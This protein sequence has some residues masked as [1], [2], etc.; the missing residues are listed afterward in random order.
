MFKIY[1]NISMKHMKNFSIYILTLSFI[2]ASCGGGGGSSDPEP[3]TPPI[4]ASPVTM[5]FEANKKSIDY[6]DNLILSWSSSN[7]TSCNASGDWQGSKAT[8]G[9]ETI[10]ASRDGVLEFSI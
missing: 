10:E 7:A 8:S 2:L 3:I 4:P 6:G 5:S 9:E 1:T